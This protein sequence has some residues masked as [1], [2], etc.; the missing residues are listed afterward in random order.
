MLYFSIYPNAVYVFV[1]PVV[2][3]E[4]QTK[5]NLGIFKV[6]IKAQGDIGT[7]NAYRSL[8][9]YKRNDLQNGY[10]YQQKS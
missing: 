3:S 2:G 6:E 10:P 7:R 1:P 4:T 9:L 8:Q 5:G